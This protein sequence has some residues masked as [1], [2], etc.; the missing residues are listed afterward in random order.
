V[1]TVYEAWDMVASCDT[2]GSHT[3]KRILGIR[4]GTVWESMKDGDLHMAPLLAFEQD[5]L[6]ERVAGVVRSFDEQRGKG[7]GA[8]MSY[9]Q[10]LANRAYR[11]PDDAYNMLQRLLNK[12]EYETNKN[13]HHQRQWRVVLM[14]ER[15]LGV[16]EMAPQRKRRVLLRRKEKP[17]VERWLI[18]I[19]GEESKHSKDGWAGHERWTNPWRRV[20]REELRAR[21]HEKDANAGKSG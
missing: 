5:E 10:D 21:R 13:P 2:H 3:W 1:T 11:L 15:S 19:K 18:V 12:K 20:D 4:F 6:A 8:K 14:E 9:D 7:R 17:L 16:T